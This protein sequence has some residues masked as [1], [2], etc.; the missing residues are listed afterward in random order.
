M[1]LN[2]LQL[3]RRLILYRHHLCFLWHGITEFTGWKL[4][5]SAILFKAQLWL[6]SPKQKR[7]TEQQQQQQQRKTKTIIHEL[8]F[9]N[10]FNTNWYLYMPLNGVFCKSQIPAARHFEMHP[11]WHFEMHLME[12][13]SSIHCHFM[14]SDSVKC[15]RVEGRCFSQWDRGRQR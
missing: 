15:D 10:M 5:I 6:G 2:W 14:I 8:S 3:R 12:F 11:A 7:E 1:I 4:D 9:L 13:A